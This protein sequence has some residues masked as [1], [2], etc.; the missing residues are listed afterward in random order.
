[1]THGA[2][3]SQA[4]A[5]LG[6]HRDDTQLFLVSKII[7]DIKNAFGRKSQQ[8]CNRYNERGAV[9]LTHVAKVV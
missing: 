3:K 7:E 8:I 5:E 4:S 9:Q 1:M 2:T 6:A